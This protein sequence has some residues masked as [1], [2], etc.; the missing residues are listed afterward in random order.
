MTLLWSKIAAGVSQGRL[1]RSVPGYF[2]SFARTNRNWL[3][4]IAAGIFA[5]L[6]ACALLF[7]L[8][9]VFYCDWN[10]HLW[11]M[12]YF[13]ES[14]KRNMAVPGAINTNQ[15]VGVRLILFYGHKFYALSGIIS[16][17]LGSAVTVRVLAFMALLL[18]FCHV[19]RAVTRSGG[20][21][22]VGLCLA[23]IVTW[24]IYPLTNLY[25]RSALTE[26]FAVALLTCSLASFLCVITGS[27]RSIPSYDAVAMGLFYVAA[28]VTHPLTGYFGGLFLFI[29][30]ATAFLFSD[31]AKKPALLSYL[32]ITALLSFVVL[33]PWIHLLHKF[34]HMLPITSRG[35]IEGF[36]NRLLHIDSPWVRLAPFP[37]DFRS[38]KAGTEYMNN[39]Y[40]YS[41]PYLDAQV[42]FPLLILIGALIYISRVEKGAFYPGARERA[43]AW[44][45][46]AALVVAF[47][48]SVYPRISGYVGD[49][50][51][52]LQFPYRL[53]TYV[54][55][56]ALCIAMIL[57]GR[58]RITAPRSRQIVNLCLACLSGHIFFR[59]CL[60]ARSRLRNHGR[61]DPPGIVVSAHQPK[62]HRARLVSRT[63]QTSY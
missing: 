54:N 59:P 41:T 19:Y 40:Y 37:L 10:N 30:G 42:T 34:H 51:D 7:N 29:L 2:V 21:R 20:N 35:P 1:C 15:L 61:F 33:S 56:S 22:G 49:L 23:T 16:A 44:V 52:I 24:A 46:A 32:S 18:Q 45:S 13:G 8:R 63:G 39:L 14:I 27:R 17:V 4:V 43:I 11:M 47:A 48:V 12:E 28:A 57:A 9:N 50:F 53:I 31:K 6:S 5:S 38:I 60:E 25:N 62:S 58:T 3:I 55:M 36:Q 26:F